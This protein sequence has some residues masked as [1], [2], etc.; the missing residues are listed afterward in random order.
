MTAKSK[1]SLHSDLTVASATV[2]G[3][4]PDNNTREISPQDMRD[5]FSLVTAV[6]G[7]VIDSFAERG[8][9]RISAARGGGLGIAPYF[10]VAL[11]PLGVPLAA[12]VF[13]IVV[14]SSAGVAAGAGEFTATKTGWLKLS[15]T[16]CVNYSNNSLAQMEVVVN[17][18]PANIVSNVIPGV[19]GLYVSAVLNGFLPV[20]QGDIVG[21]QGY[22]LSGASSTLAFYSAYAIAEYAE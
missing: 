13:P 15:L 3:L 1:T 21:I 8:T 9:Q 7:D 11:S 10:T 20:T 12:S 16:A 4:L 19:T 18:A 17:G 2:D 6:V 5:S 14:S 22:H